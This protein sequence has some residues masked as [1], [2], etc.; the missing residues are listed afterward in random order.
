MGCELAQPPDANSGPGNPPGPAIKKGGIMEESKQVEMLEGF[1]AQVAKIVGTEKGD[2]RKL[3]SRLHELVGAEKGFL[4]GLPD[5]AAMICSERN[6]EIKAANKLLEI[7][8]RTALNF[9]Q[10][11]MKERDEIADRM[12]QLMNKRFA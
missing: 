2:E 6:C 4:E 5:P 9:A 3:F 10:Q 12:D 11:M 7:Q 1:L 8:K